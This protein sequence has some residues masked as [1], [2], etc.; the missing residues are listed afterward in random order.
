[1]IQR[2]RGGIQAGIVPDVMLTDQSGAL[3][4]IPIWPGF[5]IDTLFYAAIWL[6]LFFGLT[7]AKRFIRTRRGRCPRCGYDLQGNLSAGCPECGWGR[8][9]TEPSQ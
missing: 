7:S 9:H 4:L 6:G 3:P 8:G 1:M 5:L 2:V